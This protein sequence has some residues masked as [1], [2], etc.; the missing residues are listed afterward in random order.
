MAS[1]TMRRVA[2]CRKYWRS[3][4]RD[5]AIPTSWSAVFG[6]PGS[7]ARGLDLMGAMMASVCPYTDAGFN[8]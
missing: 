3:N 8:D 4:K 7:R 5:L 6:D 1:H 2:R